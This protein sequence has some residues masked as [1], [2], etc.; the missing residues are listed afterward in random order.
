VFSLSPV[1]A[2]LLLPFAAG[3]KSASGIFAKA[4]THISK[5]SYSMYLINLAVVAEVIRDNF[6]PTTESDRI[7]KYFLYWFCVIAGSTLLYKY[8]ERPVMNLRDK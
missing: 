5:I 7:L 1:A 8:F 6:P 4:I 2:M 3:V